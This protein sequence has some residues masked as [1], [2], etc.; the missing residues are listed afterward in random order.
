MWQISRFFEHY[1]D[2]DNDKW[3]K[4]EGGSSIDDPE[5]EIVESIQ[6]FKEAP[7]KPHF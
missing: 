1:R 6:R 7:V 3:V 4:I 5:K 2:Q